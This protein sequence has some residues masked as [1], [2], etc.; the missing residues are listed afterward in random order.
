MYHVYVL[1]TGT[2]HVPSFIE[3]YKLS[4]LN[5]LSFNKG[6]VFYPVLAIDLPIVG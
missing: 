2:K 6:F 5:C 4:E 1:H 3:T